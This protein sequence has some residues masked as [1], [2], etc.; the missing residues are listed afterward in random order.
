MKQTQHW[1]DSF[2]EVLELFNQAIQKYAT[3]I[4]ARNLLDDLRLALEKLVQRLVGNS[5][6]LEK[7]FSAVG[8][9]VKQ[10]GGSTELSNM[11]VTLVDYYCKY[12]NTYIKHDDAVIEE[13]VEFVTRDH[14][15][16]YET[17]RSASGSRV[18]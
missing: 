11:F 6:S 1:L 2:P 8:A 16:L 10:R 14:G 18:I 7:Q 3:K 5:K 15:G 4:F 12:Q 9:F 13:E 17:F